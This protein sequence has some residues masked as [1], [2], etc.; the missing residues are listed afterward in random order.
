MC[1]F[2]FPEVSS[3]AQA[4]SAERVLQQQVPQQPSSSYPPGEDTRLRHSR[5]HAAQ[6]ENSL[7]PAASRSDAG[8]KVNDSFH[9]ATRDSVVHNRLAS[10]ASST[11]H[12]GITGPRVVLEDIRSPP[13]RSSGHFEAE[14]GGQNKKKASGQG[15]SRGGGGGGGGPVVMLEPLDPAVC[16]HFAL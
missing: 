16:I 15:S 4:T 3:P 2:P 1:F 7:S 13:R 10:S 12:L 8:A 6:P 11:G 14:G 5:R 9:P